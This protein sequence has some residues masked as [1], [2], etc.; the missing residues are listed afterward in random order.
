VNYPCK[1]KSDKRISQ[2]I[3]FY[4]YLSLIFAAFINIY[5]NSQA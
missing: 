4:K 5:S 1:L 3:F 2:R